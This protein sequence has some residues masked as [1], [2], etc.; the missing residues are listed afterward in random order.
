[1]SLRLKNFFIVLLSILLVGSSDKISAQGSFYDFLTS[2]TTYQLGW[3]GVDDDANTWGNPH[4]ISLWSYVDYPTRICI[5]KSIDSKIRV[6][7]SGC[8]TKL[9][10]LAYR[11]RFASPGFMYAIDLN[12]RYQFAL[13]TEFFRNQNP[14]KSKFKAALSNMS[15]AVY[16]LSGFGYTYKSLMPKEYSSAITF[17]MGAGLNYWFVKNKLGLNLQTQAKFGMHA[18]L[19]RHGTN[20]IQHSV[21]IMYWMEGSYGPRRASKSSIRRGSKKARRM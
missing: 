3:H 13:L 2:A 17:N 14:R 15:L 21:G 12:G 9:N 16:P 20:Y 8:Y 19:F 4:V 6:E 10:P 11:E 18:P 7:L 1:M 5:S